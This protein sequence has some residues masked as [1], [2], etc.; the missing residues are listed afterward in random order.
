M[1]K[2][3]YL[4]NCGAG[5]VLFVDEACPSCTRTNNRPIVH[6]ISATIYG[7]GTAQT[8]QV[9]QEQE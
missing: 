7:L 6:A 3:T 4:C 8:E 9:K 2:T 1:P 5:V